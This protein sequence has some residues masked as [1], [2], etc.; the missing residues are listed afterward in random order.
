[1]G[2]SFPDVVKGVEHTL[3][4]LNSERETTPANFK[5]KRS[6]ENQLTSTMLHLLS[7]VS[8]CH[9]EPL[10]DFLL[11]KAFFLEEW[12]RRLC[13]TLKEEDNASGP[14]TTGEKHKKELIS[15]AI[16]SLATSLGD[17]HSPELAVKLQE[18]YSNVN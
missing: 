14:S 4:S 3:Q 16:R 5:Y 10:T 15:R 12:L 8:S 1:Y 18:L 13:V 6:L 17:G 11:R 7:L 2:R 9:C